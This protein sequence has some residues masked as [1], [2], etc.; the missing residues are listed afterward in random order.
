MEPLSVFRLPNVKITG[1]R[2]AVSV[3]ILV[4]VG[5]PAVLVVW[6]ALAAEM[7]AVEEVLAAMEVQVVEMTIAVAHQVSR[8]DYVK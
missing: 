6:A 1:K 8:I 7:V 5:H 4:E 2:V 3:V